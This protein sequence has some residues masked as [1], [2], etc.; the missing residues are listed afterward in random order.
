MKIIWIAML[1]VPLAA[2][3]QAP[4]SM[5]A[6]QNNGNQQP[7]HFVGLNEKEGVSVDRFIG[8]PV[9]NPV[10]LSHGTL[11]IHEILRA[12]DPDHPGPQGAVLQYRKLLATAQLDGGAQT[13][14]ETYPDEYMFFVLS[15]QGR[16]DNGKDYWDLRQDIAILV[17][18]GAA[19]RFVNTSEDQPLRMIMLQWSGGPNAKKDLIVRDVKKLPWCEENAHWANESHCIFS[20]NDG[21]IAGERIYTVMV[22]PWSVSQPHSHTPGTEEIWT[23]LTPEPAQVLLGSDLR[24]LNQGQAYLVPPTGKT[25][26]SNMNFSKTKTQWWLY[27]ARGPEQPNGKTRPMH[28]PRVFAENPNLSRDVTAATI[29]GKPL[30]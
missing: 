6:A 5:Q 1:A 9:N 29:A 20:A 11:V 15:G 4:P 28:I 17:P 21:L 27:I 13:P 16:L 3:A 14:L 7:R 23:L 19:H 18:P 25:D 10:H 8:N 22:P 24:Q 26:H 2:A 12:G 30:H